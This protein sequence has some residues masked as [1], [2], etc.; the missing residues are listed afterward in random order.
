MYH[1]S[2]GPDWRAIFQ[3]IFFK[4]YILINQVKHYKSL[5]N[6]IKIFLKSNDHL[7]QSSISFL[8]LSFTNSQIQAIFYNLF[9]SDP[10]RSNQIYFQM[11]WF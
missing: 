10:M 4:E 9:W 6:L 11:V 1:Y 7:V 2:N 5:Q 8:V 3:R